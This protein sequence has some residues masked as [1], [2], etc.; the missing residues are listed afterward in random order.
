M[1]W[2]KYLPYQTF[3]LL[4][5]LYIILGI[6]IWPLFYLQVIDSPYFLHR[7]LMIFGGIGSFATGFL[8]TSI[9][10]FTGT[11]ITSPF[12][13]K[14]IFLVH[15]VFLILTLLSFQFLFLLPIAAFILCLSLGIFFYR[16]L[17]LS[18]FLMPKTYHFIGYAFILSSIGNLSEFIFTMAPDFIFLQK[19]ANALSYQASILCLLIGIGSRLFTGIFG[20]NIDEK[21][22]QRVL[23]LSGLL[24]VSFIGDTIQFTYSDYLFNGLRFLS[25]SFLVFQL[26]H[27]H[28]P[29]KV[30]NWE[31]I[32]ISVFWWLVLV[33]MLF[34]ALFPSGKNFFHHATYIGGFLGLT[35]IVASRIILAHGGYFMS[36]LTKTFRIFHISFT[37][38]SISLI[39]RCSSFFIADPTTL[40]LASSL[41]GLIG[42]LIWCLNMIPR[43]FKFD[44]PLTKMNDKNQ[45][46]YNFTQRENH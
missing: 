33:G 11:K 8:L 27:L 13:Y 28:R 10:C 24:L 37:L 17:M 3:F 43:I 9:P 40:M 16:R 25:M 2:N 34:S 42:V 44:S 41:T 18:K 4:G 21:K 6:S 14:S 45:S 22:E 36:N 39:L 32:W 20:L 15:F 29:P 12:E 26:W 7:H 38:I 30:K 19:L 31:T 1:P 5:C 35:F 46:R 23:F